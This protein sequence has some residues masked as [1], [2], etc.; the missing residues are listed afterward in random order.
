MNLETIKRGEKILIK[1]AFTDY[2]MFV[3]DGETAIQIDY[4]RYTK[5]FMKMG[6][7]SCFGEECVLLG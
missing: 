4:G 1:G 7:G 6:V 3:F 2:L 5:D